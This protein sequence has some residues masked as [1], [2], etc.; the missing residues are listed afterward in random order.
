MPYLTEKCKRQCHPKYR[1]ESYT[2]ITVYYKRI[3]LYIRMHERE[4]THSMHK[5]G[6]NIDVR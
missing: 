1:P 3:Y 4:S 2:Y 5:K 6:R